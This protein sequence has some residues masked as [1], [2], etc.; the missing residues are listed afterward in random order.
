M[1]MRLFTATAGLFLSLAVTEAARAGRH[2]A[3]GPGEEVS[4]GLIVRLREGARFGGAKVP[5]RFAASSR[6]R[7]LS[8]PNVY[9][10]QVDA[11]EHF[12]AGEALA[13]DPAVEFVEPDRIR[14]VTLATPNDPKYR[15]QWNLPAI[16]ALEAWQ[17]FPGRY[18]TS[19]LNLDRV[20]VAVLDTGAD[21]THPDF[22]NA[23]NSSTDAANGGQLIWLASTALQATTVTAPACEWQDDFGHGT[24]VAGIVAAAANNGVGVA[25]LGSMVELIIVKVAGSNGQTTDSLLATAILYAIGKGARVINISLA[26]AGYSRTLQSAVD[27][28]WGNNVV[29]IG[30]VGNNGKDAPVYPAA[31]HHVLGVGA[32]DVNG[33]VAA[34]S[35]LGAAVDVVAPGVS[36]QSTSPVAGT[37]RYTA[38]YHT[39]SGTS[40]AAP[41]AAALAGLLV[42]ASPGAS[43]DEIVRR[44]QRSSDLSI[45]GW[46][47]EMGY[48]RIDA[49]RAITGSNWRPA[50]NGGA[51]GQIRD[52]AGLALDGATVTLNSIA[53]TTDETGLFRFTAVAPG[54][55][56]MTVAAAGLTTL[57]VPVTISA[58]ADT[59][60]HVR[61]SVAY[62][63]LRGIAT[64]GGSAAAGIVV[65][66]W[67]EGLQHTVAVTNASGQYRLFVPAGTYEIRV[68]GMFTTTTV[69]PDQSI[70]SGATVQL[71][72]LG[73]Q[74]FGRLEGTVRNGVNSLVSGA[75]IVVSKTGRS[76]GAPSGPSGEYRTI[77][78]PGGNYL[79]SA[80]EG[81]AGVSQPAAVA[82]IDNTTSRVDMV[83]RTTGQTTSLTPTSLEIDARGGARSATIATGSSSLSWAASSNASWLIVTSAAAGSGSSTLNYTAAPNPGAATRTGRIQVNE[84]VLT[85]TQT[86]ATAGVVVDATSF[87]FPETGGSRSFAITS[88][89]V[90]VAVSDDSWLTALPP[91]SGSGNGNLSIAASNNLSNLGRTGRIRVNGVA[92]TI[93]QTP[94]SIFLDPSSASVSSAGG[95]GSFGVGFS[96]AG[97]PW[98]ATSDSGWLTVTGSAFGQGNANVTYRATANTGG[99][100]R[101]GTI[102]VNGAIFTLTQSGAAAFQLSPSAANFASSGGPGA[103]SV[104]G[105]GGFTAVSNADWISVVSTTPPFVGYEVARNLSSAARSGTISVGAS[106][107]TVTQQGIQPPGGG[108][109]TGGLHFVPV[110]PCRVVDTR[111]DAGQFGKPALAPGA[112]RSFI[113]PSSGCSIPSAAKAYALNVTVVPAG[114]LGY[115]TIFPA[116]QAQPLVSTLN[117]IDGRVKANAAIVPAGA[118]GAISV[119]ATNATELVVDI[120]GYF[121]EPGTAAEA[122]AFYPVAP[123]RVLDTR[124]PN[125]PLGG[126][127]LAATVA[128]SFPLLSSNCGIPA[129]ARAYS[130][131]ATVVPSGPLG[132]LTLF[133]SGR[134]QPLVSTLNAPTGAIV[135][136]AAILPAGDNGAISAYVSGGSHLI[137]DINGYFAPPGG[138][139]A[140]RF[141]PVSPCRVLDSRNPN[142]GLSGPVLAAN[143]TRTWPLPSSACGLPAT[144][145]AYSLNATVVP[146]I[147]L[148]YLTMW[149]AG[150]TQ[151]LVSTLNAIGDPIVANAAIVPAGTSGSIATFVTNQTHLILD[152]NGYFAP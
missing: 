93:T 7:A 42:M 12:A 103:F 71:S 98:S 47:T 73:I 119:F 13:A 50:S 35:N 127:I 8:L 82:I 100:A 53:Q 146:T 30:A 64:V 144:A 10:V 45:D 131:N 22:A 58:G 33:S 121:I 105:A 122:L 96:S 32:F 67:R 124:N 43:A 27:F 34:F 97:T 139:T 101:T 108:T 141:F 85:V 116:G 28:A 9:R 39:V 31:N 2:F 123:C 140:Q 147:S 77:P 138:S 110:Q 54:D 37:P 55:Y 14:H 148:G 106:L 135:A 126:P 111:S 104:S 70:A 145:T 41:H 76:F 61:M 152:T 90:W 3:A 56:M 19:S 63:T 25:A 86:G 48:G 36:I 5:A 72:P 136:N 78:G 62:G 15:E 52:A 20:K 11:A 46:S 102:N 128:R 6:W 92:I 95:D 150:Q 51:G 125:G 132:F 57:N 91:A 18:L 74:N 149:P 66:A 113:V 17:W 89:G 94:A 49:E 88:S 134:A 21:C 133:Q 4:D 81:S 114:P 115:M 60:V 80:E 69:L 38:M 83:M 112:A 59:P 75:Q 129:N 84:A 16:H 40:M 29:L 120:N 107:F 109:S 142:G 68:G 118:G 151:P 44:I 79:A 24:V 137:I 23:G 143:Q 1:W 65:A 87:A 130:T 117:S 99:A 26:G